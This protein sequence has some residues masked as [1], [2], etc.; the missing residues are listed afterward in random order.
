LPYIYTLFYIAS[1]EG[2]PVMR[3][4]WQEFPQNEATFELEE[5]FMFGGAMLIAPK[6]HSTQTV[7][8]ATSVESWWRLAA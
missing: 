4:M 7:A 6:L 3:P 1:T 8:R 2:Q 5:Q